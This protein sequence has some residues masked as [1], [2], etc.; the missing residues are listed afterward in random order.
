MITK[1]LELCLAKKEESFLIN[2]GKVIHATSQKLVCILIA[3]E[4]IPHVCL[5]FRLISTLCVFKIIGE[6]F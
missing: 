2:S 4:V 6:I 3:S 5:I 1:E